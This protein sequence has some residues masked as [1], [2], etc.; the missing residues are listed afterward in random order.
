MT[1]DDLADETLNRIA[2]TLDERGRITDTTPGRYCYV[3]AKF[4]FLE[5]LRNRPRR[6]VGLDEVDRVARPW[7]SRAGDDSEAARNGILD[8]LDRCLAELERADREL[9]L[10][11]YG[12][13]HRTAIEHR[14]HVAVARGITP[15]ALMIRACRIRA[16]LEACVNHRLGEEG[17]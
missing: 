12:G 5:H 14:R 10:D 11:Y 7:P 1:P 13:P 9:I 2:R 4:V 3:V 17:T 8:A 6:H 16:R 15:N